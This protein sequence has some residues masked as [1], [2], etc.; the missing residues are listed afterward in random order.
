[1]HTSIEW[2][3]RQRIAGRIPRLDE[4]LRIFEADWNSQ[5]V[6]NVLLKG[7]D[8]EEIL[9]SQGRELLRQYHADLDGREKP[10][11]VELPFRTDL[12]DLENG[13]VLELPLVG[14]IDLVEQGDN[15]VEMKTTGRSYTQI[16]LDQHLQITAYAY[17]FERLYRRKPNL[18]L[19]FLLKFRK[20]RIERAEVS[21]S[22]PDF[23]R[24]FHIAKGV[25]KAIGSGNYHPNPGWQCAECEF[26]EACQR[27]RG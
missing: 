19:E 27:W 11:A 21:R 10:Q 17:A 6:D 13:E 3:N 25:L 7:E 8:S 15:L 9:L 1:M 16:M 24:L 22:E 4:L 18:I 20:P 12:V 26:F 23:V 5:K 14:A 2:L